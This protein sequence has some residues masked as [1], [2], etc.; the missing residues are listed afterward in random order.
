MAE[1][2]ADVRA[3]RPGGPVPLPRRKPPTLVTDRGRR[4]DETGRAHPTTTDPEPSRTGAGAGRSTTGPRR[5]TADP[6]QA[7][8]FRPPTESAASASAPAAATPS[9]APSRSA[10][11]TSYSGTV[12]GL[13]RRIRQASL[14]PQL[15]E[16]SGGRASGPAPTEPA[17]DIERDADEV[18]N[19][20][21][22]MQRG[23]QR[24][25]RQ[26]AEDGTGLGET[27]QGTTPGGDGR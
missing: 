20:M 26:N 11:P 2:N 16:G 22:S 25:R 13:P 18:R 9:S 5:S 21:A 17:E 6:R 4:V 8:G 27:A 3:T 19:R 1:S 23:W 7:S 15:R 14:V 10:G 24:G 12:D